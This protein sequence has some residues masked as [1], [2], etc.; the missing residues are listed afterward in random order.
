MRPSLMVLLLLAGVPRLH[1]AL[2]DPDEPE[3]EPDQRAMQCTTCPLARP[4]GRGTQCTLLKAADA[5]MARRDL[6]HDD[7]EMM[8]A[9][10]LADTIMEWWDA[11]ADAYVDGTEIPRCPVAPDEVPHEQ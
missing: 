7:P 10:E 3:P 5:T 11:E 9:R 1:P 4:M 6:A 2:R 8:G